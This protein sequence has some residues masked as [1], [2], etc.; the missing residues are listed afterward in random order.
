MLLLIW[1]LVT[2]RLE[3]QKLSNSAIS[4]VGTKFRS[5][6]KNVHE[7]IRSKKESFEKSESFPHFCAGMV[8]GGIECLV[9]HPL[10]T[11]RIM[12]MNRRVKSKS[13]FHDI[14]GYITKPHGL[15]DLYRGS[16]S[17]M[18]GSALTSSYVYGAN[19]FLKR[20]IGTSNDEDFEKV[21]SKLL[22]SAFITGC[23]D[24]LMT[25][26]LEMIKLRQ[27]ASTEASLVHASFL[28]RARELWSEAG[29]FGTYRGWVPTMLRE[30]LGSLAFFAAFPQTKNTLLDW[31]QPDKNQNVNYVKQ[32]LKLLPV[33]VTS[34]SHDESPG[35]EL[36]KSHL[37]V[38]LAGAAAGLAYVLLSHPF[39][40]VSIAMQ[41]D[42]PVRVTSTKVLAAASANSV[43]T[44]P[45]PTFLKPLFALTKKASFP[46][47]TY[48]YSS[49]IDCVRQLV[50]DGG[51]QSL[52][53]GLGSAALRSV[54]CYAA[55]LWSYELSLAGCEALN[56]NTPKLNQ[57]HS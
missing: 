24:V 18:I 57:Y 29:V 1:F 35:L 37:I 42:I 7:N 15:I 17:E 4:V 19:D 26:P 36:W 2:L 21:D 49:T 9:G 34:R 33:S 3:S 16:L 25:K 41:I 20:V 14:I 50:R 5:Y 22:I 53:Q 13:F 55:S 10:E 38:L 44:L 45:V 23:L 40:V 39:D 27:Q 51:V 8:A 12:N 32:K 30:A 43:A 11:I 52:Y 48:R 46:T 47:I 28:T 54:P 56:T 6:T 31:L